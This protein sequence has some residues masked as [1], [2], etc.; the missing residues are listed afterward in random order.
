MKILLQSSPRAMKRRQPSS[1]TDENPVERGGRRSPRT[2]YTAAL[3]RKSRL[4]GTW[5]RSCVTEQA[6]K[7]AEMDKH[8]VDA[9]C[10]DLC[11]RADRCAARRRE[12]RQVARLCDEQAVHSGAP[13]PRTHCGYLSG[14]SGAETAVFDTDCVRRSS[15]EIVMVKSYTEFEILGGTRRRSRRGVR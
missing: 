1:R 14:V 3:C 12:L 9:G 8:D 10:R 6:L 7:D 4:G 5:R 15:S 2:R 11:A 13:H